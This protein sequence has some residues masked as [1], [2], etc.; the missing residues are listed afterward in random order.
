MSSS[1]KFRGSYG[2]N[3]GRQPP[4]TESCPDSPQ[5]ALHAK[6]DMSIIFG[7]L[8]P[9]AES[10]GLSCPLRRYWQSSTLAPEH[11]CPRTSSDTTVYPACAVNY[12]VPRRYEGVRCWEAGIYSCLLIRASICIPLWRRAL[13]LVKS[14]QLP[15]D[16]SRLRHGALPRA[17]A[18]HKVLPG[19]VAGLIEL[20]HAVLDLH[21][22][23]RPPSQSPPVL[24]N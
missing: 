15:Q 8:Y 14:E 19:L 17:P 11:A 13:R 24:V 23:A 21:G 6:P 22:L 9:A 7:A 10:P 3:L 18:L 5:R 1:R 12:A 16:A 4:S 2:I 20:C